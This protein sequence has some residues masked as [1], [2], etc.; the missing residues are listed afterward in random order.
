MKKLLLFVIAAIAVLSSCNDYETYGDLKEKERNAIT[1]FISDSSITVISEDEF[2][3]QGYVTNLARN[4]FVKLNKSGVYMQIVNIGCGEKLKDGESV[5]LCCRYMEFD[6]K[7]DSTS[8]QNRTDLYADYVDILRVTRNS[9]TFTGSFSKGTMLDAYGSSTV[10]PGWLVPFTYINIGRQK[11]MTD[12]KARVRLIVPH[13][14]GHATASSNVKPYYYE[15]SL[16]KE[17]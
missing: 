13:S 4:E 16:E 11:S 17:A 12:E 5:N 1:K 3:A 7:A 9:G 2:V 15:I 14:Q 8:M 6:I 10:P